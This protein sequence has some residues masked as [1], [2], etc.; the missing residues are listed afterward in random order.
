MLIRPV[1]D[2]HSEFW[3]YYKTDIILEEIIPPLPKDKETILVIAGDLGLLLNN[4]WINILN[5]I[6][7]RFRKVIHISGNHFFY[8]NDQ[9]N[10]FRELIKDFNQF[11]SRN[12]H[13][14]ENRC[15][16]IDKTLFIG[17]NLWTDFNKLN[18]LKMIEAKNRM[19]D[20]R[21][22]RKSDNSILTPEE[23]VVLFKKSKNYIF[24]KIKCEKD[25]KTVVVTHHGIS[26][27]SIHNDYKY[28]SLN[29]AFVS[30]LT[31]EIIE[32]GPILWI[33]GH[34]HRSADYII[35]NTRIVVNP[36]GYKDQEEN[37]DYQKNLVIE[38]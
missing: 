15:I 29:S 10:M 35:G 9:F 12:V 20:F 22:I 27:L 6:S 37:P 25:R 16:V 28:D 3:K 33:H 19:N 30:D 5:I 38:I 1:S 18:P 13:F 11:K 17:A 36:Y 26:P 2:L 34:V 32:N 7:K 24:N 4:G 23:T 14:L 21:I 8:H 31:N